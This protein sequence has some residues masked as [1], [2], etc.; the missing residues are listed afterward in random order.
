MEALIYLAKLMQKEHLKC[1]DISSSNGTNFLGITE[2]CGQL[3]FIANIVNSQ[4]NICSIS[5]EPFQ[6][7]YMEGQ[8]QSDA[9]VWDFDCKPFLC[10]NL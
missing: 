7:V 6:P 10:P 8:H 4:S 5:Q 9:L 3:N 2:V 1:V